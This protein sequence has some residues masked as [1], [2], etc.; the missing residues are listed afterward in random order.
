MSLFP[1][2][3]IPALM[4]DTRA[5]NNKRRGLLTAALLM[6]YYVLGLGA[7]LCFKE[8]G[9]H[10]S[11][12][13]FYFIVGNAMGIASTALLMGVYARMQVNLAMVLATS[14]IFALVQFSFWLIYHSPLTW[15]QGVGILLVGIGTTLAARTETAP[16]DMETAV[17]VPEVVS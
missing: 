2:H 14:G 15:L 1:P 11:R 6:G 3:P 13:L 7:N 16:A 9:S 12:W 10:A 5:L 17:T 8:G 4:K